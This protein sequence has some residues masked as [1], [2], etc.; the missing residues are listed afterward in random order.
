[1]LLLTARRHSAVATAAATYEM[2]FN[3]DS[4][5]PGGVGRGRGVNAGVA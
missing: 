3:H 4:F 5:Y 2:A 1:M